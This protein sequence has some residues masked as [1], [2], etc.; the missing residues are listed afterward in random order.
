MKTL[1]LVEAAQF[2]HVHQ[3]TLQK[4]A[5]DGD[6]PGVKIGRAWVFV[7]VDLLD[8]LRSQYRRRA[9]QGDAKEVMKCHST[10]AK[11]VPIGGLNSMLTDDEY[12]KALELPTGKRPGSIMTN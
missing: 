2:L 3:T 5:R 10:N 1:N 6:I 9:L 7:D 8:Y 11:I 12:R 4:R